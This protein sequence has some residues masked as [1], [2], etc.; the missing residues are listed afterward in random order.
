MYAKP[1][2]AAGERLAI[3]LAVTAV[4][5]SDQF[6]K[7]QRSS[8]FL[9]FVVEQTLKGLSDELK[10]RTIGISVF[11]KNDNYDTAADA[12]VR[13]RA[14]DVRRRLA[15]YYESLTESPA[16]RI[17]LRAGSYVP[18][19]VSLTSPVAEHHS[20]EAVQQPAALIAPSVPLW[21]LAAPTAVALLLAL[22]VIS[23]F[24]VRSDDA[25]TRFWAHLLAHRNSIRI[26]MD[27]ANR[28]GWISQDLANSALPFSEVAREWK[29]PLL[30]GSD[31]SLKPADDLRIEL[32]TT[33]QLQ[34][35]QIL[36]GSAGQPNL[37]IAGPTIPSIQAAAT[38]L[39]SR[40]EF[41]LS[42]ALELRQ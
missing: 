21:Q 36:I 11:G 8:A 19:F 17:E 20:P 15:Q 31:E 3:E 14:N 39:C 38:R 42:Q 27:G 2:Y 29:V 5:R 16:V 7:S 40:H 37:T 35:A 26:I 28:S 13:V 4:L 34:R 22:V 18:A 30:F 1:T 12:L 9:Q 23:F 6:R 24:N 32:R 10:E 33:P 41:L 25:Y